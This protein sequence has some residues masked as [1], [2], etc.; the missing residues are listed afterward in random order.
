MKL[1]VPA[2]DHAMVKRFPGDMS[3]GQDH[4]KRATCDPR[5]RAPMLSYGLRSA[6][7]HMQ[8]LVTWDSYVV[9]ES[10]LIKA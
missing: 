1:K 9:G 4:R 2:Y 5:Q 8:A 3:I 10:R 7:P 6:A